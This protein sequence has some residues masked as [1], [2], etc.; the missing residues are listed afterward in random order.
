MAH[1]HHCEEC[2]VAV[3][4]CDGSAEEC[5]QP[6]GHFCSLHHPDPAI[7]R[8]LVQPIKRTVITVPVPA[9]KQS[10]T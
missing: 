1:T 8:E 3:A 7:R 6:S 9:P 10:E 2:G 5:S 4:A